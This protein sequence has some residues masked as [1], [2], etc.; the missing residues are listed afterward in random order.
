MPHLCWP[1]LANAVPTLAPLPCH[2]APYQNCDWSSD[3][4][5]QCTDTEKHTGL[6]EVSRNA[7][8]LPAIIA[9]ARLGHEVC[10]RH[11]SC[12]TSGFEARHSTQHL[13][14]GHPQVPLWTL[15]NEE[16]APALSMDPMAKDGK[17]VSC[18][19]AVTQLHAATL[20][21]KL[22]QQPSTR[23]HFTWWKCLCPTPG[24][25]Q[26]AADQGLR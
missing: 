7:E 11:F 4:E 19:P 3:P 14:H 25:H 13:P 15:P 1:P 5:S 9:A 6:W 16:G 21:Q 17:P 2:P 24:P 22:P 20:L 18:Q 10:C 8:Q 12:S 23:K 26:R